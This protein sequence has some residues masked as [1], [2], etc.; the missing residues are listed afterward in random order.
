[1]ELNAVLLGLRTFFDQHENSEILIKSDNTTAIAYINRMGGSKSVESEKLATEI[2]KF[3]EERHLWILA[4]HN[5]G[6]ENVEADFMSRN[7]TEN[8][9]RNLNHDIFHIIYEKWG[10]PVV[11]M[12]ASS[13]NY[14]V[15]SY[16]SWVRDPEAIEIN[17]FKV[18]WDDC[19][20]NL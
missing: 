17:A 4:T 11:D 12:F 9:E 2:W 13:L 20:I 3:C 19:V 14:K 10:Y 16:V 8:N 7:F 18:N 15:K 6:V 1:M 5:P